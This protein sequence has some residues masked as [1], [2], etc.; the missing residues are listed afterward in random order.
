MVKIEK[1]KDSV[2]I[3]TEKQ[4]LC[5]PNSTICVHASKKSNSVDLKLKATRK[6]IMSF[7]YQDIIPTQES[8]QSAIDYIA[9][10]L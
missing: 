1:V 8:V 9:N 6:T 3:E 5:F 10:I 7:R 4:K 2:M